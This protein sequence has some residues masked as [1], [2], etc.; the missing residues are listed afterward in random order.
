MSIKGRPR[1]PLDKRR[2]AQ[3]VVRIDLLTLRQI[4]AFS[5]K[6]DLSRS[7]IFRAAAREYLERRV[8]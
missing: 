2:A 6:H 3:V 5:D 8:A 1:K 4:D 7:Q